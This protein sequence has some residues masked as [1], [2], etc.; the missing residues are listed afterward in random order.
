MN[1]NFTES[2]KI[3]H[4]STEAMR[5][6]TASAWASDVINMRGYHDCIFIID[7]ASGVG[8]DE[9]SIQRCDDVTPTSTAGAPSYRYRYST[10]PD[11]WTAWTAVT[12][13]S[14][15]IT[16]ITPDKTYEVHITADEVAGSSGWEYFRLNTDEIT[17]SPVDVDMIAIL[18]NP[19]YAEDID[20]VT[21][22]V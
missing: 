18:Y 20:A 14:G 7:F 19:R 6:R 4:L 15:F 17:N 10:T 2:H 11:T 16:P 8:A 3:I 13:S 22:I 21:N 1:I 12:S 9:V 5:D